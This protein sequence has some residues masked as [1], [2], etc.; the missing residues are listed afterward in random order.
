VG[1]VLG[2]MVGGSKASAM[3]DL[4]ER[5]PVEQRKWG[6]LHHSVRSE[7][8]RLKG[9]AIGAVIKFI[10][11]M[12]KQSLFRGAESRHAHNGV[13]GGDPQERMDVGKV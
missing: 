13:N 3:D 5:A 10:I 6:S 9:L 7:V 8:E 12:A 11:N 1:F 2:R 4:P